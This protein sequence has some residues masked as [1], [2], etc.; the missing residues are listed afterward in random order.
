MKKV[1]KIIAGALGALALVA[2]TVVVAAP[3]GMAGCGGMGMGMGHMGMGRMHGGAP[4][5]MAEKHLAKMK[6]V[7]KITAA[8]EPA[9]ATFAGKA[10]EQAKTM[11]ADFAQ[12]QAA[13]TKMPAPERMAAR[14]AEMKQHLAGMETMNAAMKDMYAALTPE[15]RV[16]ADQQAGHMGGRGQGMGHRQHGQ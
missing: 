8:Q 10:T 6:S 15:Q 5:A 9:W 13:D 11:Q 3:D 7:L 12:R 4:G 2:A 1:H 16:I 14:I